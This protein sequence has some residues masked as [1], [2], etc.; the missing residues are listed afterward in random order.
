MWEVEASTGITHLSL[1]GDASCNGLY[2]A[3]E[4][5]TLQLLP[6]IYMCALIII[7]AR[8]K[9]NR[10]TVVSRAANKP[11]AKFSP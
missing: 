10:R 4:G 3:R 1:S 6:G 2:S 9:T 7:M 11:S 5:Q 8:M